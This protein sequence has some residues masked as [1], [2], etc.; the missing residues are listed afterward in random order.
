M[1]IKPALGLFILLI[2]SCEK[3]SGN[4]YA[5]CNAIIAAS[6]DG[7]SETGYC[8]F[9]I[10]WVK[11]N[12]RQICSPDSIV[13]TEL[14]Y[15]FM[16]PGYKFN[17]HSQEGVISLSFDE[18]INCAKKS[19]RD[20]FAEWESVAALKFIETD[21]DE[22][23][24]IKIII[25]DISQGGLGY[26]PYSGEPCN[27]LAGLLVIRPIDNPT[28]DSYYYMAQHEVGHILG[29]GHVLSNNVM[30]PDR[31]YL[32]KNLQPGDIQG[33]QAIYGTN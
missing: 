4:K 18:V 9:G 32:Y 25:A 30:N 7:S 8:L 2:V 20:A 17:T 1:K 22:E 13:P 27:E 5:T 24:D 12:S 28:C 19:I 16:D 21:K 29:L 3:E 14:T 26:P 6:C 10:D 23:A 15:T 33:I 11:N 31:Y